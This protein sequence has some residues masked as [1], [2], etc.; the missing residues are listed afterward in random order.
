MADEQA[1]PR[2]QPA[3]LDHVEWEGDGAGDV[4]VAQQVRL[5][6]EMRWQFR[7]SARA[8]RSS[9]RPVRWTVTKPPQVREERPPHEAQAVR[10]PATA[11]KPAG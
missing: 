8:T 9:A 1:I 2:V 7:S 11:P 3:E 5:L 4:Y 10:P 6:E